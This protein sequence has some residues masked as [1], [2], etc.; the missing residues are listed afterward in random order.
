MA[1][2]QPFGVSC[3]GG[4]NT[5]L[6][7]LEMLGQPGLATKLVNFEVDPD[8]GYRR[9]NGYTAFGDTR[10]NG[11]NEILGLAVYADGLIACSGDGI[12]FS[13]DG[14]NAW[15]Q[16]NR[17]SVHSSGDNYTAFTGR[18]MDARTNQRQSSFALYEG[19]TDYGQII[20]CDGVNKP[21]YFHMEGTGSL[22]TRTFYA[23]EITVT[24]THA[25]TVCAVHDHHLVVA[26]AD[27]AKD[28]IYY[29]HNFEPE[30]FNGAGAGS[31]KLSDQ[32]VG[33]KSFRGD[34]IIFCRNSLHKLININDSSNIAV[35]PIT[36][37]VGCL[38]SHSIQ[39]IG[40]DLVFLSP[41]G[42]RSVAGTSRIGDVEL[43]SVSR[44]IQS[45]ISTVAND[46]NS[47][48]I[49]SAVL[50]SKSQY[51]LFYSTASGSTVSAK[52]IIG[53]LTANG[54][55]WSET[56]GIQATG[57]AS[58]FE[59]T[60]IEKLYHG[61]NQGYVY[62]HNT[63]NTFIATGTAFNINAIYQTPNYD[64]GDIG[65]RKTLHYVKISITPEGEVQPSLRV[66]YDY[67][68]TDIPQPAD[69]VL[70][71]VPLPALFGTAVFSTAIFGAS[72][73]PM[74]RQAIQGSGSVCNF[75]ISSSDQN[76]PYA[77]NGLYINY[78]PSGRR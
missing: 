10:P 72:N 3:K 43:G 26:G 73:D 33:L 66:R 32:V 76:A 50:R 4:L 5:N 23:E 13:P 70:D 54:F 16:I 8:G 37:N 52:G 53:T 34:L 51:R 14:E 56:I 67:E 24:N 61:D 62:N 12:F 22:T 11:S 38:S 74:L 58:G 29:S 30:N 39:E 21:F 27:A 36:Q 55:E 64:F 63:G 41:D 59:A 6:N 45:I 47:F 15:L 46:I 75:R 78:V 42:I 40:G 49:T 60:G 19:N 35:V 1:A 77:I 28:T 48:T 20:I 69:Y 71:S 17:A 44:Q 9:I 68:D 31:I 25:P 57:F 65:T 18:S 7:Q 2:S